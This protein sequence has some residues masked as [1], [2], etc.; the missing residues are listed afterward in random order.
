[1]AKERLM[2]ARVWWILTAKMQGVLPDVYHRL[3]AKTHR[4]LCGMQMPESY[5]RFT[6]PHPSRLQVKLRCAKCN[7]VNETQTRERKAGKYAN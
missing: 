2:G 7:D 6:G 4:T 1:V 5:G 3:D